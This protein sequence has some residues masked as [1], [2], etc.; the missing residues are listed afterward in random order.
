MKILLGIILGI[1]IGIAVGVVFP[2][3]ITKEEV[4]GRCTGMII[5]F[6]S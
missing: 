2:T 3:V 4:G 5:Q 1:E 6:K